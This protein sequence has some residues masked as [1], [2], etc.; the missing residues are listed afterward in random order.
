ML[1]S[2]DIPLNGAGNAG[3]RAGAEVGLEPV[4]GQC[5]VFAEQR[6]RLP[7]IDDLLHEEG[8]GRAEGRSD[9]VET[10]FDLAPVRWS[11]PDSLAGARVRLHVIDD[12]RGAESGTNNSL[13]FGYPGPPN[14]SNVVPQNA[15]DVDLI[16]GAHQ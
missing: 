10:R 7:R 6:P 16:G 4:F 9:R 5:D 14:N 8:F 2:T 13:Y 1:W 11:V 3:P 15:N 12:S